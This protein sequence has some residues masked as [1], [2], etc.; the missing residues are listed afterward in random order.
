VDIA[1]IEVAYPESAILQQAGDLPIQLASATEPAP[2]RVETIL[3]AADISIRGN[4]VF[5]ED[6]SSPGSQDTIHLLQGSARIRDAAQ[7]V[8]DQDSIDTVRFQG[9]I[10]HRQGD[11][12]HLEWNPASL[13]LRNAGHLCGWVQTYYTADTIAIIVREIQTGTYPNLKDNALC[14]RDNLATL[15]HVRLHTA[16]EVDDLWQDMS[17]VEAHARWGLTMCFT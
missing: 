5:T 17:I 2:D 14:H 16:R 9:E 6:Q 10:L 11:D 4:T 13:R 8:G 15:P 1:V 7:G 3:P 12:L